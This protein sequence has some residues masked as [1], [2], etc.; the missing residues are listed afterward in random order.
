MR[1]GSGLSRSSLWPGETVSSG[2]LFKLPADSAANWNQG[3]KH[4]RNAEVQAAS[5]EGGGLGGYVAAEE[6]WFCH[7]DLRSF[8]SQVLDVSS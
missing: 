4:G 5:E 8:F 3:A 2:Q 6:I 7:L 1:L